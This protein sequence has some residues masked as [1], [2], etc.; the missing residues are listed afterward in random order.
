MISRYLCVILALGL[1]IAPIVS[2]ITPKEQA[3]NLHGQPRQVYRDLNKYIGNQPIEY[4]IIAGVYRDSIV[5]TEVL[6]IG[7][8]T[9]VLVYP[10][11]IWTSALKYKVSHVVIIHNHP[12]GMCTASDADWDNIRLFRNITAPY[13][14]TVDKGV[15]LCGGAIAGYGD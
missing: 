2:A 6:E 12:N 4:S 7:D 11:T 9:S 8:A 1:V 13:G 14:V 3:T 15:I 5:Y 10:D